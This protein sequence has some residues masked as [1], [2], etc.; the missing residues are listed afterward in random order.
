MGRKYESKEEL[1]AKKKAKQT[2]LRPHV[3]IKD[4]RLLLP[5]KVMAMAFGVTL[6]AVNKWG[7]KPVIK[8]GTEALLYLPEVISHRLGEDEVNKLNP[9]QEKAMLD[10]ARR[11]NAELELKRKRGIYVSLDDVTKVWEKQLIV[12]RQRIL[13][14]PNKLARPVMEVASPKEAQEVLMQEAVEML[15]DLNANADY[16][17]GGS[18][19]N[20]G[21][22]ESAAEDEPS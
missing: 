21:D 6:D 17:S 9:A 2:V 20:Q 13:A 15:R 4:D 12:L 18:E 1:D 10:R 19:D 7:V 22:V 11:E 5:M 3:E 16:R 14:M 8:R